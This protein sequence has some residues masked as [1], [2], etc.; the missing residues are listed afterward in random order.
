MRTVGRYEIV[1]EVGRGATA[2]VSLARQADLERWVA[3]KE[4]DAGRAADAAFA[5]RFLREAR[6]AGSLNHPC[7]VTVYEYFEHDGVPF[8]AMEYFERGSLRPLVGT[9]SVAQVGGVASG[10]LAGLTAAE[11]RGIVHRDLKPEN[12]MVTTAGGVKITDFGIA[13]ALLSSSHASSITSTGSTVGTPAYM[14]P[15]LALGDA[16]GPWTDLYALGV[17]TY[18]L[19]AGRLPFDREEMPIA[20]LLRH[21]R[22]AVTPLRT[23]RPEL[24]PALCAWVERLLE[25]DPGARP[26]SAAEA[27]KD[28]DGVLYD[29]AG[30]SWE[31]EASL[32][33]D[34]PF[35]VSGFPR[36]AVT[37][38]G[39]SRKRRWLVGGTAALLG[40][41]ALAVAF[42]ELVHP[43]PHSS[44]AP[45]AATP[46]P[47]PIPAA[48]DRVVAAVSG[49]SLFVADPRGRVAALDRTTLG[50]RAVATE[51]SGP[52]SLVVDRGGVVVADGRTLTRLAPATLAPLAAE[53]LPGIE[54]LLVDRGALVAAFGD[55]RVCRLRAAGASACV[56]LAARPAALGA[57][58]GRVYAADTTAGTLTTLGEKRGRLVKLGAPTRVGRR[59]HGTLAAFRDRLYVPV[60]RGIAVVD[61]R[62]GKVRRVALPVTPA[63]IWVA[64]FSRRLFATLPATN[65]VAVLDAATGRLLRMT[66]VGGRPVALAGGI[67]AQPREVLVVGAGARSVTRLDAATGR[68]LGSRSVP[69][70]GTTRPAPVVLRHASVRTEGTKTT[71]RFA[72][73]GGGL[74]RN[75][76]VV[77]DARPGDGRASIELWQGGI[78][79]TM[80]PTTSA[81]VAV[82]AATEPGRLRLEL[83]AKTGTYTRLA[84]RLIGRRTVV[85]TLVGAQRQTTPT[86]ETQA[87]SGGGSSPPAAPPKTTPLPKKPTEPSDGGP[88]IQF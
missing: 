61:L 69:G 81:G 33:G 86:Q 46:L 19:L 47:D 14:A 34:R 3:L 26:Q 56:R 41:A 23:L 82:R 50:P 37:L 73:S 75:G 74:D 76:L 79:S 29:A 1:R 22:E 55:G 36:E 62:N 21:V 18:E 49:G 17:M 84:A 43:R 20:V 16:V 25:K 72:L 87:P 9:L 45:T 65:R 58:G 5:T 15:E 54:S 52:R 51:P 35:A 85:A 13:K 63:A 7:V 32:G 28:L 57:A 40:A 60:E 80:V 53:A 88:I 30:P 67:G 24:D 39:R 78:S 48:A 6:L 42:V 2:L 70:L 68:K 11:S 64:P 31:R 77:R 12:I 44:A 8:I 71:I 66:A 83:S 38:R 4:L 10:V 59:P 27:A